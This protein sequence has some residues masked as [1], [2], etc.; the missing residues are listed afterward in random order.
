[1]KKG[2]VF[3]EYVLSDT[4]PITRQYVLCGFKKNIL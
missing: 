2:Y 1:M 3:N 4:S